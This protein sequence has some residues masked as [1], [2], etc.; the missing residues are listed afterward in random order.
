[1]NPAITITASARY[2]LNVHLHTHW[3]RRYFGIHDTF[4][5]YEEGLR[6]EARSLADAYDGYSARAGKVSD[7]IAE[8]DADDIP[9]EL[10]AATLPYAVEEYTGGQKCSYEFFSTPEEAE[11][12][13]EEKMTEFGMERLFVDEGG[14]RGETRRLTIE[15]RIKIH[16]DGLALDYES[17]DPADAGDILH[18]LHDAGYE[19]EELQEW[20]MSESFHADAAEA[21][22]KAI[23]TL[24]L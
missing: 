13:A 4:A 10:T 7:L 17:T 6:E 18:M 23:I 2:T 12:D 8:W 16:C 15:P 3:T 5:D 19:D 20:V 11:A 21:I 22:N 9:G 24:T 14:H 1:M